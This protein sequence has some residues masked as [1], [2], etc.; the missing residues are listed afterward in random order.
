MLRLSCLQL[1]EKYACVPFEADSAIE[2]PSTCDDCFLYIAAGL[3][4]LLIV[5]RIYFSTAS[6]LFSSTPTK[7]ISFVR[8]AGSPVLSVE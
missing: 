6:C 5:L 2:S 1:C 4:L 8:N 7:K 3:S